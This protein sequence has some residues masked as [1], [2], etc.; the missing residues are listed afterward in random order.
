M[1]FNLHFLHFFLHFFTS[2]KQQ[3]IFIHSTTT[4]SVNYDCERFF[5][6]KTFSTLRYQESAAKGLPPCD[7]H[8]IFKTS[9]SN[10][11]SSVP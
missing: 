2:E 3:N 4:K 5:K 6:K 11:V 8:V 9:P 7:S 1:T 10:N